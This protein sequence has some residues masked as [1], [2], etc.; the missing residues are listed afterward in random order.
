MSSGLT[1]SGAI[2]RGLAYAPSANA[3][4]W[5]R[6]A[7]GERA[8]VA[9]VKAVPPTDDTAQA[10]EQ[11]RDQ[12]M[13]ERGVDQLSLFQA[14]SQQRIQA[15]TAIM[16]ETALRSMQAGNQ[17]RAYVRATANFVDIRV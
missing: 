1:H 4:A 11:I 10:R 17:A 14:S 12:V 7:A 2:A 6:D 16:V 5:A 3:R 8:N 13:V 9:A 15:E